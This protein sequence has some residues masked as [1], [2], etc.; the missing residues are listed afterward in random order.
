MCLVENPERQYPL[1]PT[2]MQTEWA[3]PKICE[4]QGRSYFGI[5]FFS[6]IIMSSVDT[7]PRRPHILLGVTGSVAAVKAPEIALKLANKLNAYVYVLLTQGGDNF[8]RKAKDYNPLIWQLLQEEISRGQKD[9][10]SVRV[11]GK[12]RPKEMECI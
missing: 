2:P 5:S 10:P 9:A 6:A 8:W 1:A 12:R 11:I 7:S 3:D 4:A